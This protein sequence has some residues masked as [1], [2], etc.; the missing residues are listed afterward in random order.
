MSKKKTWKIVCPRSH[1]HVFSFVCSHSAFLVTW[2]YWVNRKPCSLVQFTAATKNYVQWIQKC[3]EDFKLQ[4]A[5]R[6]NEGGRKTEQRNCFLPKG[7]KFVYFGLVV[8]SYR[9]HIHLVFCYVRIHCYYKW[10]SSDMGACADWAQP[11][12]FTCTFLA[13]CNSKDTTGKGNNR[14]FST[15]LLPFEVVDLSQLLQKNCRMHRSSPKRKFL[16]LKKNQHPW[17]PLP[18]WTSWEGT[19]SSSDTSLCRTVHHPSPAAPLSSQ[20]IS[21]WHVFSGETK[22]LCLQLSVF[23]LEKGER[24]RIKIRA[25]WPLM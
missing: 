6:P 9:V 10:C 22:L 16:W 20:H 2:G 17:P 5:Q 21:H 12:I 23:H 14:S 3:T 1:F 19:A 24:N 11:C 13:Y 7:P 4:F 8:P 18:H 25:A 15:H